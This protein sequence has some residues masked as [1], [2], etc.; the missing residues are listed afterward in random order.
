MNSTAWLAAQHDC[1][2]LRSTYS[3]LSQGTRPS[4]Q[5]RNLKDMGRYLQVATINC[6]GLLVVKKMDAFV[7]ERELIIVPQ[8]SLPTDC[9][10]FM[11]WSP[12]KYSTVKGF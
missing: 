2:Q 5:S 6:K 10:P 9:T 8:F 3:H 7:H 4:I 12:R 11:S 1:A